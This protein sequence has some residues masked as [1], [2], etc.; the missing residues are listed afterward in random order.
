MARR[1]VMSNGVTQL[2]GSMPAV[3]E[4]SGNWM[5]DGNNWV[6]APDCG[7]PQP[8]PPFGPP[9]FSGPAGQP[10]WYP[11]ANGGVSFGATAPPNP[12]RGHQWWDGKTY[13]LFDGAAWVAIGGPNVPVTGVTDG[14]DVLPGQVGEWLQFQQS[15][16][17]PTAAQTVQVPMGVLQPGDWSCTAFANTSVAVTDL[18][19]A[20]S[21]VP[22]GFSNLMWAYIAV[23]GPT[24][25]TVLIVS[26]QARA[27]IS[28]GTAVNFAMTTNNGT[29][30]P[31]AGTGQVIFN[32]RRMR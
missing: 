25:E 32:A 31:A 11:G 1:F 13:W 17:V 14:S 12:V 23:T 8:C 2:R 29:A 9:V 6:C 30:G 19:M 18:Q 26:P 3:G 27:L 24:V 20:L 16:N 10:P 21:P 4:Q 5:W 28:L 7:V 15:F 22:P